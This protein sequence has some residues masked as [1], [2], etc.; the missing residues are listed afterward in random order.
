MRKKT[1]IQAGLVAVVGLAATC[2]LA[3]QFLKDRTQHLFAPSGRRHDA[4]SPAKVPLDIVSR[5]AM[6]FRSQALLDNGWAFFRPFDRWCYQ[7]PWTSS[8]SGRL[9][10]LDAV[11]TTV[12]G[13][14]VFLY[15]P[16]TPGAYSAPFPKVFGDGKRIPCEVSGSQVEPMPAAVRKYV[17]AL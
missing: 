2:V 11:T 15:L 3:H 7:V 6:T 13:H 10:L 17:A 16:P 9:T 1:Y 4:V 5:E 12:D 14:F 8:K